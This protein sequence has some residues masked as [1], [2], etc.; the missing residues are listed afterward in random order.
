MRHSRDRALNKLRQTFKL[1]NEASIR[2]MTSSNHAASTKLPSSFVS[3]HKVRVRVSPA[4]TNCRRAILRQD[5]RSWSVMSVIDRVRAVKRSADSG[6]Q[7]LL[8]KVSCD[9]MRVRFVRF[10]RLRSP[11]GAAFALRLTCRFLQI[12][13]YCC[14]FS[15][16]LDCS[17]T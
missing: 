13:F 1:T 5:S 10:L 4:L 14:S 17:V 16:F 11:A 7:V 6:N 9:R 2:R 8:K 15:V 12:P 3:E